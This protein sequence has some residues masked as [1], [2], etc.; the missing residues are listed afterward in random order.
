MHKIIFCILFVLASFISFSQVLT[1]K[2]IDK[3]SVEIPFHLGADRFFTT[4]GVQSCNTVMTFAPKSPL[5][6]ALIPRSKPT[7]PAVAPAAPMPARWRRSTN[8]SAVYC[9]TPH[10]TPSRSN[11]WPSPPTTPCHYHAGASRGGARC[12]YLRLGWWR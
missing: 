4:M 5:A 8:N 1:G 11:S 2:I 12:W 3:D 6:N 9:A 7:S 10:Q